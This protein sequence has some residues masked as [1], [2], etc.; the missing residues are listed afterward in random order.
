MFC[1]NNL[2]E[3]LLCSLFQNVR[4]SKEK[5]KPRTPRKNWNHGHQGKIGTTAMSYGGYELFYIIGHD[6]NWNNCQVWC[7]YIHKNMV[8]LIFVQQYHKLEPLPLGTTAAWQWFPKKLHF[9]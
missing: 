7:Q 1:Q 5:L 6:K 9:N 8:V 3:I 2:I 4:C